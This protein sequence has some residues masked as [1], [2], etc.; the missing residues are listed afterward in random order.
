VLDPAAVVV[1]GGMAQ[2]INYSNLNN[3]VRD[4]VVDAIKDKVNI[5]EGIL[6]NDSGMIGGACL[7]NLEL[8]RL[9]AFAAEIS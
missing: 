4:K 6:G 8:A 1:S 7:A 5:M 2:F 9:N 3:K